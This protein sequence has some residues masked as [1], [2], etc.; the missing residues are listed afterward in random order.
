[1][2]PGYVSTTHQHSPCN[3]GTADNGN[4]HSSVSGHAKTQTLFMHCVLEIVHLNIL[5]KT[6]NK[7]IGKV[8]VTVKSLA[9]KQKNGPQ[10]YVHPN[11]WNLG[12]CYL[13]EYM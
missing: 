7:E 4:I 5:K 13:A 2:T 11:P 1:M 9:E 3:K 6:G 12:T 8:P 10:R